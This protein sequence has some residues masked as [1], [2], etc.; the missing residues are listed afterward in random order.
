M[1]F[2]PEA[3]LIGGVIVSGAGIDALRH[4]RHRR[5]IG[6]AALPLVFGAHQIIEAFAWWGLRGS[7]PET[8]GVLARDVYLVIAFTLPL[9]V[10]LAVRAIEPEEHRRRRM[11]P[12]VVLGGTITAV[13]L[14]QMA[15]G[16]VGAEACGRYI[17]YDAGLVLGGPTAVLYVVA[18]CAPLILTSI[19]PLRLFGAA[20][21]VAVIGLGL[22]ISQGFISLWCAWAAIASLVVVLHLRSTDQVALADLSGASVPNDSATTTA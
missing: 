1:C 7:V 2:A 5:E 14:G 17:A 8:V 19:R 9:V 11:T 15:A 22:L 6:L 13:L 12:F 16:P 21:L 18:V 10:P 4:V 20:N 3:D